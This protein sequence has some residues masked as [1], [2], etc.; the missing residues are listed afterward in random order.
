MAQEAGRPREEGDFT[1]RLGASRRPNNPDRRSDQKRAAARETRRR[2]LRARLA[3]ITDALRQWDQWDS[4][5]RDEQ[6][7]HP[8]L[9]PGITRQALTELRDH[10]LEELREPER[11]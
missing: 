7:Q 10:V 3:R 5:T 11:S 4:L 1:S 6:S 9:R 8:E 2:E